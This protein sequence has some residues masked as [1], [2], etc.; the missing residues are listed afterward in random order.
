MEKTIGVLHQRDSPFELLP[1]NEAWE[2]SEGNEE[3][4]YGIFLK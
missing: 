3:T 1:E 2:I 4:T